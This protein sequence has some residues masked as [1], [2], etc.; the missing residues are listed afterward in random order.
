METTETNECA[1]A[2]DAIVHFMKKCMTLE[3][4]NAELRDQVSRLLALLELGAKH[5]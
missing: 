4:E 3:Q 1:Y 2:D 5:E